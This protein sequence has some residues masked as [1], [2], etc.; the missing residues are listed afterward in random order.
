MRLKSELIYMY[1]SHDFHIKSINCIKKIDRERGTK[2]CLDK[3]ICSNEV[4][5]NILSL[6][7]EYRCGPRAKRPFLDNRN[8][9]INL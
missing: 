1:L 6:Y 4:Q 2:R 7:D 3:I 5:L 8:E 9:E